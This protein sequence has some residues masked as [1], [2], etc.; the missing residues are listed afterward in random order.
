VSSN[1][2]PRE[3]IQRLG[4]VLRLDKESNKTHANIFDFIVIPPS[5]IRYRDIAERSIARNLVRNEVIRAKFFYELSQNMEDAKD[6]IE[7]IVGELG[8]TFTEEELDINNR[9]ELDG[10]IE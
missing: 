4:R 9:K 1:T 7:D 8:M 10:T 5:G 6:K 2:D 3:Y